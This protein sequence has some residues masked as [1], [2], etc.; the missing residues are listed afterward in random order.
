M[1]RTPPRV[2]TGGP[3]AVHLC[4]TVRGR[5][6]LYGCAWASYGEARPAVPVSRG[7][8]V[9]AA[10][11]DGPS[12]RRALPVVPRSGA[13]EP[14]APRPGEPRRPPATPE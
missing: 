11:S 12:L 9:A 13:S 4:L 10:G 6:H 8:R 7:R 1:S 2:V 3:D 14:G 5:P